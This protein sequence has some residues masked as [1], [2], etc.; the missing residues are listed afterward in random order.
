LADASGKGGWPR[1]EAIHHSTGAGVSEERADEGNESS[2]HTNGR[3]GREEEAAVNGVIGLI[4]ITEHSKA[5]P[6]LAAQ[7]V[8][9]ELQGHDVVTNAAARHKSSLLRVNDMREA[10]AKAA[11]QQQGV[12]AVVSVQQGNGTVVGRIGAI[13]RL[14][15]DCD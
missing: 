15:Q 8:G 1:D 2:P 14:M 10:G 12:E 13:P 7:Q 3:E 6:A 9:Q 4:E 5:P 11:G